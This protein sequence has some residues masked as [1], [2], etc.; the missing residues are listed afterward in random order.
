MLK[1][2]PKLAM[3]LMAAVTVVFGASELLSA[4]S[5]RTADDCGE[6]NWCALSKGGQM[7]C[8]NCCRDREFTDGVCTSFVEDAG[9]PPLVQ[10]CICV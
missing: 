10:Y 9:P 1:Q 6:G 5:L 2:L 7:N 4:Q 3:S 8:T